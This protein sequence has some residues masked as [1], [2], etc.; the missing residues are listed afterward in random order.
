M[1]LKR[2]HLVADYGP[3][4]DLAWAE[5]IAALR[6]T[7]G[8]DITVEKVVVPPFNTVNGGFRAAQLARGLD[9]S[10]EILVMNVD[11]RAQAP[12][13]VHDG[14]GAPF[15]CAY[16]NHDNRNTCVGPQ[17]RVFTPAAGYSL[18]L[19]APH[20]GVCYVLHTGDG[21]GQFRSRDLFPGIIA[22]VLRSGINDL[23]ARVDLSTIPQIPK[24]TVLHRDG[25]GNIKLNL[26]KTQAIK[27]GWEQGRGVR[28]TINHIGYE[29]WCA[30]SIMGMSFGTM[31]LAPGSSGDP[32]DPFLELASRFH[33]GRSAEVQ[34]G[35]SSDIV[36]GMGAVIKYETNEQVAVNQ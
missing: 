27:D 8:Q 4:D 2:V 9:P 34:V 22:K 15:V 25:Y 12:K 16:V 5:V 29:A 14:A 7:L 1:D 32:K 19:M 26:T 35:W 6:R 31:V 10:H 13:G 33:P 24:G 20:I 30:P 11:P 18:S 28:V 17:L 3:V 23:G 36:P 21:N